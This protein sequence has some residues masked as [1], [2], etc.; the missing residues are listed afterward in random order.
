M[1]WCKLD[2][3]FYPSAGELSIG[4]LS[5]FWSYGHYVLQVTCLKG[6]K[7]CFENKNLSRTTL[8]PDSAFRFPGQNHFLFKAVCVVQT[9]QQT[10]LSSLPPFPQQ[11]MVKLNFCSLAFFFFLLSICPVL[12]RSNLLMGIKILQKFTWNLLF[13]ACESL[14]ILLLWCVISDIYGN[15]RFPVLRF[16]V[17]SHLRKSFQS[18]FLPSGCPVCGGHFL[19]GSETDAEERAVWR[20]SRGLPFF[21]H[22]W[23]VYTIWIQLKLNCIRC[24][25]S[26]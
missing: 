21:F 2:G 19:Q 8:L 3:I 7:P 18:L 26:F 1:S 4:E 16:F 25:V 12:L 20:E 22:L 24:F 10:C 11:N 13:W 9:E 23:I 15:L 14:E 5:K 6:D 17:I